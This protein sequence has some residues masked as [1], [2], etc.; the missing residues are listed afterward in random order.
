M[1]TDPTQPEVAY[2]EEI[3]MDG[4][5]D[6]VFHSQA[7][8]GVPLTAA[9]F[10]PPPPNP[11]AVDDKARFDPLDLGPTAPRLPVPTP[12]YTPMVPVSAAF[13]PP[14]LPVHTTALAAA[15]ASFA[16]SGMQALDVP[17]SMLGAGDSTVAPA[18]V[19]DSV[20]S[21][22]YDVSGVEEVPVGNSDLEY[23]FTGAG[24]AANATAHGARVA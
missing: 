11:F 20:V 10:S 3:A 2:E 5:H 8:L 24:D 15:A 4:G 12:R 7:G 22:E 6:G 17:A 23:V 1:D 19:R 16:Y 21:E 13:P 14:P 9:H 18:P